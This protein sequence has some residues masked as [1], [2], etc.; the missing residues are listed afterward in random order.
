MSSPNSPEFDAAHRD[1]FRGIASTE[2]AGVF[3]KKMLDY[4]PNDLR[5]GLRADME[6]R[7]KAAAPREHKEASTEAYAAHFAKL[8][9]RE[10]AAISDAID[11]VQF[12]STPTYQGDDSYDFDVDDAA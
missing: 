5:A 2:F 1:P 4:A 8:S 10:Q 7:Q 3:A 11:S 6:E 9:E 12:Q